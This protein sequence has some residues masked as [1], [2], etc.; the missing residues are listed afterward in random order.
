MTTSMG[1]ITDWQKALSELENKVN[2]QQYGIKSIHGMTELFQKYAFC[3]H[4][5]VR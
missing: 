1:G 5:F 2:V 4:A 3:N